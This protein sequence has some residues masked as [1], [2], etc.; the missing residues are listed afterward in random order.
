[1]KCHVILL[2]TDDLE[3]DQDARSE[4][5]RLARLLSMMFSGDTVVYKHF[6]ANLADLTASQPIVTDLSQNPKR[7]SK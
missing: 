1:M 7:P 6:E 2:A 4:F 5:L 3:H